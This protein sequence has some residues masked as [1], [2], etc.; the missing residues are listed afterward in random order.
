MLTMLA[1]GAIAMGYGVAGLF[2]LRFWRDTKDRLF[3]IFALAF[4]VLTVNRVMI[5]TQV[6]LAGDQHYWIRLFAFLL[7]L[8]AIIDKNFK[9]RTQSR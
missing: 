5:A 9:R 4:F 7:I 1:T 6:A 2:F 8:G 3:A